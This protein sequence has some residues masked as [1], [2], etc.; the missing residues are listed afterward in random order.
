MA[1]ADEDLGSGIRLHVRDT[2]KFRNWRMPLER[3]RIEH[4]K[5]S[6]I[7]RAKLII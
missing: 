4:W 3:S 1:I 6:P 7:L 2:T 5:L